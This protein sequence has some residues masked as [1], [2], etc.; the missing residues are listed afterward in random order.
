MDE[1]HVVTC[2]LLHR[3]ATGDRLLLARRGGRVSTYRGRWA[4]ISGT[5]ETT[6]DRQ[7]LTE[8]GEETG[9]LPGQVRLLARGEPLTVE[10]RRLARR[11]VVHP[12]LFAI[13]EPAAIRLD[14]EHTEARWVTPTE[15]AALPT[16]PRLVEALARVYPPTR[17]LADA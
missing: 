11:W 3:G 2:F 17:P 1:R 13:D 4:G 10:D 7:A 6:P 8:I 9:L 16:V 12:Y 14:W 15:I 5:I